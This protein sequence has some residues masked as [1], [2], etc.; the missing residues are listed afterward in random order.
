MR[1]TSTPSPSNRTLLLVPAVLLL[2]AGCDEGPLEELNV[3]IPTFAE[4]MSDTS[5]FDA[6]AAGAMLPVALR[7]TD[8]YGSAVP[9]ARV[10]WTPTGDDATSVEPDDTTRT[11]A[12]GVATV[13]W[14]VGGAGRYSL[15]ARA[16]TARATT[17]SA[18][19]SA[20]VPLP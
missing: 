15:T 5:A 10:I 16:T 12:A 19:L 8:P 9:D 2:L 7:F 18:E 20:Q 3:G 17:A 11:D 14:K 4:V 1:H 6:A 13:M